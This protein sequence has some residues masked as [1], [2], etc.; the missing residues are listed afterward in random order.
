MN[1]FWKKITK[2]SL[3]VIVAVA[4]IYLVVGTFFMSGS[5]TNTNFNTFGNTVA[6]GNSS[7]KSTD[8]LEVAMDKILIN[9]QGGRFSYMK[10]D[11]SLQ[12]KDENNKEKLEK[13][14]PRARDVILRYSATKNG[15][16]MITNEGK[17]L[18]KEELKA[19]LKDTL[20][21]EIKEVFFRDFVLAQ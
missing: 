3:G 2:I 4:F 1:E 19:I 21:I 14:M 15:D 7:T 10:A 9:M 17:D 18:Y 5:Q 16:E 6:K 13:M 11:L 12:M 8:E 20:G